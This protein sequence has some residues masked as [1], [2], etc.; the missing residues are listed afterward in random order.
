VGLAQALVLSI[1]GVLLLRA[2]R[3]TGRGGELE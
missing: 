2:R 1:P 3:V